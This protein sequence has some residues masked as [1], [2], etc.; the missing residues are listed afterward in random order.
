MKGWMAEIGQKAENRHIKGKRVR[1][2]YLDVNRDKNW[3]SERQK[4]I[5]LNWEEMHLTASFTITKLSTYIWNNIKIKETGN[6][7]KE[8]G[9]TKYVLL[10]MEN[11]TNQNKT[12]KISENVA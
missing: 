2:K 10:K 8:F 6:F 12:I 4:K 5:V 11:N 1:E 3:Q 9:E 7:Q